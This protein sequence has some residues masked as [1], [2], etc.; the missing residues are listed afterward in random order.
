MRARIRP[1]LR[2]V[3]LR[4]RLEREMREE[5]AAHL[6]RA[7]E[8][9]VARGLT[10]GDARHEAL[11]EFGPVPF[12]QEQARAARGG[13]WVDDVVADLR[14]GRRHLRR[15]PLT[16]AIM[17]AVLAAG[18][19]IS[20]LLFSV[21]H[22]V[23]AAPPA[24]VARADDLVRIRGT[25]AAPGR[26]GRGFRAVGED[27]LR[28]YRALGGL[29]AAVAGSTNQRAPLV[30]PADPERRPREA[31]VTFVT[32]SYFSVLGVRPALGPGLPPLRDDDAAS[33]N[34]AVIAHATWRQLFAGDSGAIGATVLV[35]G[36][37]VTVV[38]VAPE[39][40]HGAWLTGRTPV[41]LWMPVAAQQT[42]RL[43]PAPPFLA[44]ARLR[45]GA[46]AASATAAV[47]LVAQRVGAAHDSLRALRPSAEVAPLLAMNSDPGFD[48]DVRWMA[49]LVGLL[50]LLV[51]L[52]TCTNVSALLMGLAAARR[53][54]V[55]VRLSLGAARAQLVRQLL[56]ESVLL[57]VA[58]GGAALALAWLVLRAA[59]WRMP[60]L[61]FELAVTGPSAAFALGVALAVGVG[62]GLA[63]ALHGTRMPAAGALRDST[64]AVTGGRGRLQR[65]LVVAQIAFTQP[66][67]ALLV[68]VLL[69]AMGELAP[70]RQTELGDRLIS[71]RLRPPVA[72]ADDASP[73][74]AAAWERLRAPMRQLAERLPAVAGV[75]TVVT[76]WPGASPL[77][78]YVVHPDDRAAGVPQE[79]VRLAG[80]H[81]SP[82]YFATLGI[83]VVRGRD[84]APAEVAPVRPRSA[85]TGVVVGTDLARRLWGGADPVG[86][87]LRAASDSAP[88]ARTLTVV[89]VIDDP[90]ARFR[91]PG[92]EVRVYLPPDTTRVPR[93]L[94]VRTTGDAAPLLPAVRAVVH[95]AASA[96]LADV[97][98]VAAAQAEGERDRRAA[99][100]WISAA[101]GAA[102]LLSAVGLY[103]VVA[104][105]VG[106]RTREIAVRM[107][108]G[109]PGGRVV[110]RFVADGLR[111]AAVGV[112]AG[113]PAALLGL[114]AL[115]VLDPDF[116]ALPAG[117]VAAITA[118]AVIATA[119][120][121]AWL[122]ARRAAAVDP[123][124]VLRA[125]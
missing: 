40:F 47:R 26:E 115:P 116:P 39:R 75:E 86:R 21:V 24:G 83:P 36:T 82:R 72:T 85:Q 102:L 89:G 101:G 56:T 65:A 90:L 28:A 3:L 38:G 12:L 81:A 76:E 10:P 54:E 67:I 87:R 22:S 2:S 51:L 14:F 31:V 50:A 43:G 98:T 59:A 122:P 109:A 68:T 53:Q 125:E 123:A 34:V 93:A 35:A 16:T 13:R 27:E 29:F 119:L 104:F 5:M 1:W 70:R 4:R 114:G 11:R 69:V 25:L 73:A 18:I 74:A 106:R 78:D 99:A 42:L 94:L 124:A 80:E 91:E 62:F 48:R 84:F 55:A 23:A 57:A 95:D 17:F 6:E 111:L 71:V 44:V 110:R 46:T 41:Q 118:I 63:P 112:A 117:P 32:E 88:G 19:A 113:L 107:S 64:A 121:A 77:G 61:P 9:L 108:V 96:L 100:A 58:A 120:V 20:V 8:R 7:T 30:A 97:E 66:L 37:P 92:E 15:A 103:A 45:P 105:A 79:T 49:F 52:V 33:A 60:A